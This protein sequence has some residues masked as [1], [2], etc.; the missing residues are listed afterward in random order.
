[1]FRVRDKILNISSKK[2]SDYFFRGKY[3]NG[4]EN[5]I[6]VFPSKEILDLP[7]IPGQVPQQIT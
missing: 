6:C 7:F 4:M 5:A 1:M 2:K 3:A